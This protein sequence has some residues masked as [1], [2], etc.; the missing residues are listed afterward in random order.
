MRRALPAA[1]AQTRYG[2]TGLPRSCS[3]SS[4]N[5]SAWRTSWS[6]R[7]TSWP[8]ARSTDTTGDAAAALRAGPSPAAGAPVPALAPPGLDDRPPAVTTV[9]V[10]YAARCAGGPT[11]STGWPP[12]SLA[13]VPRIAVWAA[14]S[15]LHELV[16]VR[17]LRRAA[18]RGRP[19]VRCACPAPRTRC[20]TSPP[21]WPRWQPRY[22][23]RPS[24]TPPS[25]RSS[26]ARSEL[27]TAEALLMLVAWN[28]LHRAEVLTRAL[29][30][31]WSRRRPVLSTARRAARWSRPTGG[32]R[33]PARLHEVDP[34]TMPPLTGPPA[35]G[36]GRAARRGRHHR[37]PGA[38]P[39][40]S[41]C[42]GSATTR[43]ASSSAC[44][45]C[46]TP[47]APTRARPTC[48]A[49]SPPSTGHSAYIRGVA[50]P[51]RDPAGRLPGAAGR[52]Q[53]GRHGRAR[54]SPTAAT[55]GVTIDG[56]LTAGAPLIATNVPRAVP[57]LALR[58]R[59]RPGAAPARPG[60]LPRT[61]G[62]PGRGAVGT[63]G[64]PVPYTRPAAL[65]QQ[66]R[67]R[68][69]RLPRVAGSDAEPVRAFRERV[70]PFLT[71][72][73]GAGPLPP[74]HRLRTAVCHDDAMC[75]RY[76][77]AR[78][79]IDLIEGFGI[80]EVV[81]P[82]AGPVL[83]RRADPGQPGRPRAGAARPP[84][85]RG[86]APA[87]HHALGPGAVLGQDPQDRRPR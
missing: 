60:R 19:D 32:S 26:W 21:S 78:S 52:P 40:P 18:G 85:R 33:A 81:G 48:P 87:A 55:S 72:A 83:E 41:R 27:P 22:G 80:E 66:A 5:C 34:A 51:A 30:P 17:H 35:S 1:A 24:P 25:T 37:G 57:Y 6:T 10:D 47:P 44:P 4:T 64:L 70:R 58:E 12:K 13:L 29:T 53:P 11:S 82:R 76:A 56:V 9:A 31:G 54:R 65:R 16:A 67:P 8:D 86:G 38:T 62:R 73:A 23:R 20:P 2:S 63:D 84:A 28:R 50:R 3:T 36:P 69:R 46:R 77:S 14:R 61:A 71:D 74:G 59:R 43:R 75:G 49:R 68:Q 15:G 39:R 45:G 7:C 79:D 42:C